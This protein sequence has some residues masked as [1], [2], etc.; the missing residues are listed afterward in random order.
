MKRAKYSCQVRLREARAP[1]IREGLGLVGIVGGTE[2]D[3]GE[4][5]IDLVG[6]RAKSI[7]TRVGP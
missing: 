2:S 7:Y 6:N 5:R 1:V 3:I 4:L